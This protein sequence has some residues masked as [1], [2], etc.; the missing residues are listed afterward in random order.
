MVAKKDMA[1]TGNVIATAEPN[2]NNQESANIITAFEPGAPPVELESIRPDADLAT[3]GWATT[4]LFSKIN[5]QSDA[6]F[7]SATANQSGGTAQSAPFIAWTGNIAQGIGAVTPTIHAD[8]VLN[9]IMIMFAESANEAVAT[10]TGWAIVTNSPQGT[11]TAGGTAATRLSVFWK[12]HDGSE[13]NPTVADPGNHVG[14]RILGVRGC[15]TTGDP[16]NITSG[17]VRT[18]ASTAVSIT[19]PTTTVAN[20]LVLVG[21]ANATDATASQIATNSWSCTAIPDLAGT[22]IG[23]NTTNGNGGGFNVAAGTKA[24]AGAIGTITATLATSSVQGHLVIALRAI[25]PTATT[26]ARVSLASRST[27]P[28]RTSHRIVMRV[29]LANA[30]IA[31]TIRAQLYEG[32][33]A[34]S[35]E[36]ESGALTG[37]FTER[38]LSLTNTEA[39]SITSYSDLEIRFR[40]F[41]SLGLAPV[42]DVAEIQFDA[43]ETVGDFTAPVISLASPL[44]YTIS[45]EP[46][47]DEYS[48]SFTANEDIQAWEARL[49]ASTSTPRLDGTL[50][51]SGG[52]ASQGQTVSGSITYLE[53]LRR[54]GAGND[55][56]VSVGDKWTLLASQQAVN[57]EIALLGQLGVGR[58][59]HDVDWAVIESTEGSPSWTTHDRVAIAADNQGIQLLFVITGTPAWARAGGSGGHF[60]PPGD[61][62]DYAAFCTAAVNRYKPG[63]TLGLTRGVTTWEVWNEP[64]IPDF[65]EG[66]ANAAAYAALL[67]AAYTAIKAAHSDSIVIMAGMSRAD[68]FGGSIRGADFLTSVYAAGAGS[69][70]DHVAFHP[71]S[72]PYFP[73]GGTDNNGWKQM[74][75]FRAVMV[76]NG[77]SSKKVWLTEYGAPTGGTSAVSETNQARMASEAIRV[78]RSYQWAGPLFWYELRDGNS[79]EPTISNEHF[80]LLETNG[81]EKPAW[82]TFSDVADEIELLTESETVL[83]TAPIAYF[84]LDDSGSSITDSAG[85]HTGT[86]DASATKQAASLQESG[87]GFAVTAGTGGVG[88][89]THAAD[90]NHPAGDW[91]VT[92]RL[93][94]PVGYTAAD[95]PSILRKGST[96]GRWLFYWN[97]SAQWL[98]FNASGSYETQVAENIIPG[99]TYTFGLSWNHTRGTWITYVNGV[100]AFEAGWAGQAYSPPFGGTANLEVMKGDEAFNGASLD[101]LAFWTREVSG[102]EWAEIYQRTLIQADQG[103]S[104]ISDG[105]YRIAFFAQDVAGN[106]SVTN[107]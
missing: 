24:T 38:V 31:G 42:F 5:D 68:T 25:D 55:L 30:A 53:L 101:S 1:A 46:T 71:Y 7:V 91:S 26:I 45:D 64:N 48:Y 17:S 21:V 12:R 49:V 102:A 51:E 78:S 67:Q 105:D 16:W 3:T 80:G 34:R 72:F 83:R 15:P 36:L 52:S 93:K 28:E 87:E 19:G 37:S 43:P 20:T 77:Q 35:A 69:S 103:N 96:T 47:K 2:S 14:A 10:P 76:A 33:N 66:G 92:F 70:F 40:G 27:P 65:W 82:T 81:T 73:A 62:A 79:S 74:L 95:F 85:T 59:R 4:P 75:D 58:L 60:K 98:V 22:G 86:Y 90:L 63:G 54:L 44:T 18:T 61:V 97:R 89:I 32:A 11:G 50:I 104:Y 94:I 57:D 99:A 107:T 84:K 8:A 6:T 41:S 13:A 29:R 106:W 39:T 9:D 23:D 100:Y 88:V 56:G